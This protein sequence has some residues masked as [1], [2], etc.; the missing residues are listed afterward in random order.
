MPKRIKPTENAAQWPRQGVKSVECRK[1]DVVV[2]VAD[3]TKCKSQEASI[4]VEVYIGGVYD[5]N[6]SKSFSLWQG[7]TL[8]EAKRQA[9]NFAGTQIAKFL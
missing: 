7:L 4:D 3:W 9:A 8:S 2:R 1:R 5:F 6:E